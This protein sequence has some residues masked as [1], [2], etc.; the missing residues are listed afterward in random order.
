MLLLSLS[1]LVSEFWNSKYGGLCRLLGVFAGGIFFGYGLKIAARLWS[2]APK[3]THQRPDPNRTL[4]PAEAFAIYQTK[5]ALIRSEAYMNS[6][7]KTRYLRVA[8]IE[9]ASRHAIDVRAIRDIWNH[10]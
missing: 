10:R 7:D 3:E 1:S 2:G 9:E 6:P 8:S 5:L 4:S